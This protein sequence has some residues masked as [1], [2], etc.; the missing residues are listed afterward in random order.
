VL[1]VAAD[2]VGSSAVVVV[3][4]ELDMHGAGSLSDAVERVMSGDVDDL[5]VDLGGVSFVD[6]AGLQA[7]WTMRERA[8]AAG[9]A[10]RIVSVSQTVARVIRF[11][12]IEGL[13][14]EEGS[15]PA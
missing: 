9:V 4:G 13:L 14:P 7:L 6:S 8:E 5:A 3:T 2:R 11:A 1:V 10:F 12:G 15:A